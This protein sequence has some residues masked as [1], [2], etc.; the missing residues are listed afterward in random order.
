MDGGGPIDAIIAIVGLLIGVGLT[1]FLLVDGI[2]KEKL[3]QGKRNQWICENGDA[4]RGKWK[5]EG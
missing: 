2:G 4:A 3:R 1:L 5:W